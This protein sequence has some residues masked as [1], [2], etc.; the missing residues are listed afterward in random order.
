MNSFT[1][2]ITENQ[3]GSNGIFNEDF[4]L[5]MSAYRNSFLGFWGIGCCLWQKSYEA[6][7]HPGLVNLSFELITEGVFLLKNGTETVKLSP[8]DLLLVDAF[9]EQQLQAY[10]AGRKWCVFFRDSSLSLAMAQKIFGHK[11]VIRLSNWQNIEEKF[12]QIFTAVSEAADD[13]EKLAFEL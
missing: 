2:R 5:D 13:P 11:S 10:P 9:R 12:R 1:R 4:Y 6:T 8:G 7:Y 3:L